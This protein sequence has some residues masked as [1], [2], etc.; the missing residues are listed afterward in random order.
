MRTR[1]FIFSIFAFL[2]ALTPATAAGSVSLAI[3]PFEFV[4]T[5]GE[6]Q[7]PDREA[8]LKLATDTLAEALAKT[9]HY[10]TVDLHPFSAEIAAMRP[11]YKCGDCFLS[12]AREARA[13]YA[14][15][16]VVHKISTLISAM[17]IVVFDV[18]S[19]ALIANASGQIRGDTDE[20]YRH[21]VAFL[22]RNRLI[23]ELTDHAAK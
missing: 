21:G 19:G 2:Y 11:R 23:D 15:V 13:N 9:G 12:V 3:F 20:A 6:A 17:N 16:S 18:S 10:T 1:F 4:D 14:A 5:S 8:R 7:S 22:V